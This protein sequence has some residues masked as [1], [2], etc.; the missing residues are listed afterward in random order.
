MAASG[1]EMVADTLD[2]LRTMLPP[3]LTRWERTSVMSPEVIE[4][5]D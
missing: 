4:V 1:G 3:K 2:E 5:W